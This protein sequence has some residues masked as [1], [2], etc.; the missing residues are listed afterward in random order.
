MANLNKVFLIGRLTRDPEP[1]NGRNGSP[2]GAKF[3]FAVN[4]RRFNQDSQQWEDVPVFIDTEIWNRGESKQGDRVLQSLKKGNQVF[5]EGH[6]RMDQWEDKNGGGKRSK[7]LI[8]IDTFQYLDARSDGA[9]SGEGM[10]RPNRMSSPRD[11]FSSRSGGEN[12][13]RS[14]ENEE[15]SMGEPASRGGRIGGEKDDDIPF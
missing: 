12:L 10:S 4:N 11:S 13:N 7:L 14:Y 1:I 6:L 2:M 9:P 8:V 5:L 3:G 15:S